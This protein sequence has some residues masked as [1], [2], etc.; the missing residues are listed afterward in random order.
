MKN[1]IETLEL[2]KRAQKIILQVAPN[3]DQ[4][5]WSGRYPIDEIINEWVNDCYKHLNNDI[6]RC[7]CCNEPLLTHRNYEKCCRKK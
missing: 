6:G 5:C 2:L 1:H 4:T 3:L 7:P